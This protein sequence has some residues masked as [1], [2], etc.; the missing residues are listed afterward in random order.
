MEP[1]PRTLMWDQ[2]DDVRSA[3]FMIGVWLVAADWAVLFV[4]D[5]L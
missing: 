3:A 5:L 2:L 4:K 1:F